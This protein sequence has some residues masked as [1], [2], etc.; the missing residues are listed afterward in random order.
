MNE[1]AEKINVNKEYEKLVPPTVRKSLFDDSEDY[2]GLREYIMAQP[3]NSLKNSKLPFA[4]VELLDYVTFMFNDA[5]DKATAEHKHLF[6]IRQSIKGKEEFCAAAGYYLKYSKSFVVMPYSYIVAQANGQIPYPAQRTGKN[7]LNGINRFT[8]CSLTFKSP[9]QAA[10]FVLGQKARLDEW[11]DKRGKGLLYY[12]PE[13][14][15]REVPA[16]DYNLPLGQVPAPPVEKIHFFSI[17]K[18]GEPGRECDAKG[19]YDIKTKTFVLKEGSVWSTEVTKDYK[20]TASE[21]FRRIHIRRSCKIQGTDIIQTRD[22]LCDSPN[23][24]ASFVLGRSANGWDEWKD[25]SG[26]T[27]R[28]I[29]MDANAEDAK[30]KIIS[31]IVDLLLSSS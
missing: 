16:S 21:F 29:F 20:F 8:T 27:L 25:K 15:V 7:N 24:A 18:Q 5:V 28:N 26:N 11:V 13:L 3:Y 31:E 30:K 12:Y 9:E 2:E 17:K 1:K 19:Y 6:F 10:T 14:T 23:A 22:I 4:E